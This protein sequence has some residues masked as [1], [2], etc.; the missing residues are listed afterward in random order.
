MSI[1][2]LYPRS[3]HDIHFLVTAVVAYASSD[4]Y[5]PSHAH[6]VC[7]PLIC[8]HMQVP[9]LSPSIAVASAH[10]CN[11]HFLAMRYSGGTLPTIPSQTKQCTAEPSISCH[12]FSQ[13]GMCAA[14]G[15]TACRAVFLHVER[16]VLSNGPSNATSPV[17]FADCGFLR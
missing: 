2:G 9:F 17:Q 16:L 8:C 13:P 11:G 3:P 6:I 4:S 15:M 12:R 14:C 10:L 7:T 5:R 1:T